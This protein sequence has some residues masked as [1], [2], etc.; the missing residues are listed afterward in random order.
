MVDPD[1][2]RG[3]EMQKRR[4]AA[5]VNSTA[6]ES[7]SLRIIV[8]ITTWRARFARWS[9]MIPLAADPANG[10]SYDSCGNVLQV[11]CVALERLVSRVGAL[12][13]QDLD[14]LVAGVALCIG[15]NP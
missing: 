8:P 4:P 2:T 6:F 5:I 1:P 9:F 11:R 12:S 3:S 14:D 15:L 13:P 7:Q 10:L